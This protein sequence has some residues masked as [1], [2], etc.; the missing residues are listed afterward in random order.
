LTSDTHNDPFG[1]GDDSYLGTRVADHSGGYLRACHPTADHAPRSA[2]AA[3]RPIKPGQVDRKDEC[4]GL[5]LDAL[6]HQDATDLYAAIADALPP[7]ATM[8]NHA[9]YRW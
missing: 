7:E 5:S 8:H 3:R 4:Q 6:D 9:A 1:R 2:R